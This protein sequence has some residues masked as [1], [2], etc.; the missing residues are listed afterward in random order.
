MHKPVVLKKGRETP[1][2]AGH[3]WVFSQGIE[4][5]AT[6][7]PGEPVSVLSFD[8]GFVG[9]GI[10]NPLSDIRVRMMDGSDITP[11]A[12]YFQKRLSRLLAYKRTLLSA[13]S[14]GFRLV[15]ADADRMPGLIADIYGSCLVVQFHAV[16]AEAFRKPILE[17]LEKVVN[18][19]VI[20]ERSDLEVRKREGM[21]PIPARILKGSLNGFPRFTENGLVFLADV[22]QGQ[23][24]GFFLDQ[25]TA[26]EAVGRHAKGKTILNLFSY[27]GAFGVYGARHGA[28]HVVNVDISERAQEVAREN[29][30]VNGLNT[31]GI[32]F[33]STDAFEYLYNS[34][35]SFDVVVCDPPAF[36]KTQRAIEK[37]L[38]AYTSL[39]AQCIAKLSEN[40]VLLTSSCSGRVAMDDFRHTVRVAAYQSRRRLHILDEFSHT[41]DHTDALSF[42]EGRYL[43]TIV[44]RAL[45]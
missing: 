38:K 25:R 33:L 43:K 44:L 18:P 30:S 1:V 6:F 15:N 22:M 16:S 40:G 12:A 27:T 37:A 2:R 31:S 14:T 45:D 13:D 11:D 19:D 17:A 42:P 9:T 23:K 20:V 28:K 41:P 4:G 26:R 3:P 34:R 32:E 29:F 36:A 7:E 39:N 24:T 21:Q 10:I 8:G 5:D 35:D